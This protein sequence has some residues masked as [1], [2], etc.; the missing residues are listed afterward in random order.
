MGFS[1]QSEAGRGAPPAQDGRRRT[2]R[3]SRFPARLRIDRLC[4]LLPDRHQRYRTSCLLAGIHRREDINLP[5]FR[6]MV[7]APSIPTSAAAVLRVCSRLRCPHKAASP[8]CAERVPA[9]RSS[10]S[11]WKVSSRRRNCFR[12]VSVRTQNNRVS[13]AM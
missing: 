12:Q 7:P 3:Q 5:V 11:P 6:T 10:A 2:L 1:Y 8:T 9:L 13:L 4:F